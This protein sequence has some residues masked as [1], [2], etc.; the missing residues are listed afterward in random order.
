M[1]WDGM[2]RDREGGSLHSACIRFLDG[3][4]EGIKNEVNFRHSRLH[5]GG[6]PT[7]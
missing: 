4:R 3:H 1:K 2:R 7:P 6:H 5:Q